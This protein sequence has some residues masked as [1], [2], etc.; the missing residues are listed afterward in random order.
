MTEEQQWQEQLLDAI[1]DP[2]WQAQP[3]LPAAALAVYRNNYR[4]SLMEMLAIAYPIIKQLVGDS[5]FEGLA[6]EFVCATPSRSGN[7][8]VYGEGFASFIRHFSHARS[9]PYLADVAAMEW[10]LHRGYYAADY[11][12]FDGASIGQ[13]PQDQWGELKLPLAPPCTLLQ[14]AWAL[15]QIHAYHQP[16]HSAKPFAL[17]QAQHLI[18]F[19]LHGQMQLRQLDPA[20]YRFMQCLQQEQTLDQATSS[21][22]AIDPDF[23]LQGLLLAGLQSGW[24]CQP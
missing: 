6:R 20:G 9:L 11:T 12:A 19:R 10:G 3:L 2:Q 7:L 22:L 5:F 14:S 13:V 18:V 8:H 15:D 1:C 24:F 4:V 16:G 17:E 23:D 21:A